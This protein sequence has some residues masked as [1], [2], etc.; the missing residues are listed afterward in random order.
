MS[1]LLRNRFGVP[2]VIAVLALVF[3]M[4]GGAYAAKKYVITSTSQIKPSVL[5]TLQKPGPAGVPGA[6]GDPGAAG[7]KGDAGARGANGDPGAPGTAGTAGKP[8]SPWVVGTA[9][10]GAEL[11]GTWSV[12]YYEAAA[13]SEPVFA[14]ISTGVPIGRNAIKWKVV[15]DPG[16]S[17]A[18]PPASEPFLDELTEELCPGSASNPTVNTESTDFP[19]P[20]GVLCVYVGSSTNLNPPFPAPTETPNWPLSQ[21]SEQTGGGFLVGLE[22]A[23]A[24]VAKAYGSW[25][26]KLAE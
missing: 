10:E 20:E 3:A 15:N 17:W 24:G 1:A 7:A 8:G 2:G 12:P 16:F 11:K 18:D 5:K 19:A 6:K 26:M 21:T 14:S 22:S 4:A 13:A 25:A 23:A 9:P